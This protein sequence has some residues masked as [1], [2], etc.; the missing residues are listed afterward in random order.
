[1]PAFEH[2]VKIK[3]IMNI[4]KEKE[5]DFIQITNIH[6]KAFKNP[7]EGRIV[8]DLRE[9]RKLTISLVCEVEGKVIGHIVY[10][11]IYSKGEIIGLGLAPVAVLP[12]FQKQGIGSAL[13][14][15]GNKM[16][17]SKGYS[18]IFVLG[19]HDYYSRFGFVPAK[20]Y[21]YFS[22]FDPE[23]RHF[24][25]LNNDITTEA[26]RTEIKYCREFEG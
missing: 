14:K 6:D 20:K 17:V 26:E 23:G 16:A 19:Y 7:S 3:T 21:N 13:I 4:R 22:K 18:R 9:N 1:L 5:S 2:N 8:E 10:S 15:A 11:P 24:M 12:D 25:I